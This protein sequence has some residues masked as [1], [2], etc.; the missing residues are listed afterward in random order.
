MHHKKPIL[1]PHEI[2]TLVDE[3]GNFKSKDDKGWI[4]P[5][6]IAKEWEQQ[7]LRTAEAIGAKPTHIDTHHGRHRIPE[8]TPIY[9][10]LAAKYGIPVRGGEYIGQVDGSSQGVRSSSF[11]TSKWTGQNQGIESLK[12]T[13]QENSGLA[14]DGVLEVVTHPGFCDDELIASSS[15]NIVRENDHNVLMDLAKDGWL[16]QMG[17][18]LVRYPDM[19]IPASHA[20][21]V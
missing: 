4:N 11:C 14:K 8:L 20:P 2:P 7:I 16:K 5:D 19:A 9:L 10:K 3:A 12:E 6:E 17:F 18:N 15:W 13:I 1:P 21:H